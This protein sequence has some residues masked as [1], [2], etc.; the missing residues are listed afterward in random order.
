MYQDFQVHLFPGEDKNNSELPDSQ[1]KKGNMMNYSTLIIF[2][3][4]L[5]QRHTS[6]FFERK[7]FPDT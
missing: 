4:N 7:T 2:F 6:L 3:K 1:S 5:K